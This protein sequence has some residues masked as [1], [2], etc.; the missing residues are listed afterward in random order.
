MVCGRGWVAQFGEPMR[1]AWAKLTI[2]LEGPLKGIFLL[3][4]SPAQ[5]GGFSLFPSHSFSR[6]STSSIA[7]LSSVVR[8]NGQGGQTTRI[9]T[10]D[11]QRVSR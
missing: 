5:V 8:E 4:P 7:T 10:S 6:S 9:G 1:A 2:L 3:S 11:S